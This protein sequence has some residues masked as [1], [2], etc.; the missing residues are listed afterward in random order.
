MPKLYSETGEKISGS[1]IG[2][3]ESWDNNSSMTRDK[4]F[5]GDP[6]TFFDASNDQSWT[7][8]D[9]GEPVNITKNRIYRR[10]C[11]FDDG[12]QKWLAYN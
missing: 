10:P 12:V 2:T 6:I 8:L 5:D 7:G 9:L 3:T 11:I 1:V 4:A